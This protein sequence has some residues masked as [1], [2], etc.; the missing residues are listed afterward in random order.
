MANGA[1]VARLVP[2]SARATAD[3]PAAAPAVA[4]IEVELG[5]AVASAATA[6]ARAMLDYGA[7][8]VMDSETK[9]AGGSRIARVATLQLDHKEG[10]LDFIARARN[11]G[12][13]ELRQCID[14]DFYRQHRPEHC[15]A[16]IDFYLD[17]VF[18]VVAKVVEDER[19]FRAAWAN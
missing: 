7:F 4:G 16:A 11:A 14:A 10:D 5:R 15:A 1:A 8:G 2:P 18:E 3:K 9:E 12:R 19:A 13:R 6:V 17:A